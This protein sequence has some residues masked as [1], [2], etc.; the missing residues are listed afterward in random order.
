[1]LERIPMSL[2]FLFLS[3]A[4]LEVGG[5]AFIRRGLRGGGALCIVVG[6]CALGLYGIVVNKVPWDFSKLLG[7]YV[8]VFATVSVLTGRFVF[9]DHVP[10]S[11]WLGLAIIVA[12]GLVIQW[13]GSR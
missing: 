13:G 8:A 12:G 10:S 3:A 4:A 1:M 5:D 7:F 6:F 2:I 11:T 9:G